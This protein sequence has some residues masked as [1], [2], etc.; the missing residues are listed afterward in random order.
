MRRRWR[1]I[2]RCNGCSE[3]VANA[4]FYGKARNNVPIAGGARCVRT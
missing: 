4:G 1:G 2:E 3:R